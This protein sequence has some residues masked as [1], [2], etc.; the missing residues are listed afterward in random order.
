MGYPTN[1]I[2]TTYLDSPADSV[3]QA[4]AELYNALL[5]LSELIDSRNTADG[6]C[7]LDPNSQV[8]AANMPTTFTSGTGVDIIMNPNTERV[9][10]N[11]VAQLGTKTVAELATTLNTAGSVV[12]CSN[13][14]A[15]NPCLAVGDGTT[16]TAG[17][18]IWYRV[19]LGTQVSAT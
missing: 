10:I 18:Y 2:T 3:G 14:D 16:D 8:P 9:I 12:Y 7:P 6:I 5:R 17:D 15:G 1:N 11:D 13:G 19:A 4:R